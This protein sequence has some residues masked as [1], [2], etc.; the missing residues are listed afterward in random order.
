MNTKQGARNA[1]KSLIKRFGSEEAYR[2][3]MR[4]LASKSR[5]KREDTTFYLDRE[6]AREAGRLGGL[7]RG[8]NAKKTNQ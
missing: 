3:Y 6:L 7:K 2:A 1:R 8:Q 5:V 4:S